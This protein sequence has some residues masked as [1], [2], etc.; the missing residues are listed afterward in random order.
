MTGF[1]MA[2]AAGTMLAAPAAVAQGAPQ[3][4]VGTFRITA[5]ACS[6]GAVS[7]S[8]FR[9]VLPSGTAAGPF[10]SNSDSACG[11]HTYTLLMPGSDGGLIS[12]A[13]Q[14]EPNPA[15]DAH[16]NGL[17]AR[18]TKPTLFYGVAFSTSTNAVDP[19]TRVAV[20]APS[21]SVADGKLVG[22]LRA[23][24]A[25][26]NRQEFN[27]G[28]PKPDGSVPGNT[29]APSGSYN[30]TTRAFS[31]SWASQIQGGPFNNF[32]GLWHLEGTFVP[33]SGPAPAVTPT[34]TPTSQVSAASPIPTGGP[35]ATV[36]SPVSATGPSS[37]AAAGTPDAPATSVP[38]G[39]TT[40]PPAGP[41]TGAAL[42]PPARTATV[43]RH[44]A[45]VLGFGIVA[46]LALAAV[47][48]WLAIGWR[49]RPGAST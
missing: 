39:A 29:A 4:L 17:S 30:V 23:F 48:G 25:S 24:A 28:A 44:G 18:I 32:T 14:P 47:S 31:L 5:G 37:A 22:D 1:A 21:L 15:F 6:G 10:A 38:A 11:D 20:A 46:G 12:G 3:P 33:A 41:S 45:A 13:R 16:G 35:G 26:W 43:R 34:A 8:T 27:Q 42:S 36:V 49:R 7:G 2:V 40:V 19:Q 9:M